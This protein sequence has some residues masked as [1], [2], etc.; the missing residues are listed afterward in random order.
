MKLIDG[1][2]IANRI[3]DAIAIETYNIYKNGGSRPGLGIII[4]GDRVDSKLYVKIKQAEAVKLGIDTSLYELPADISESELLNVIRFLNEDSGID[5]IL[6]QLPLPEG[7]NTDLIIGAINSKKDADGF[8]PQHPDYVVSPVLGAVKEMITE[9]GLDLK[10][11][12]AAILY[13]SEIFGTEAKNLLTSLG[14]AQVGGLSLKDFSSLSEIK[15]QLKLEE[16]KK[17]TVEADILV[18]AVGLPKFITADMVKEQAVIIDIGTNRVNDKVVGDVD[19]DGV[20]DKVSF[21]SPVPGGVGPLTVAL[22][23]KNVLEIYNRE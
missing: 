14:L 21:I 7:L 6:V 11:K 12:K 8:H 10:S 23:F 5:A 2:L 13:N 3:K 22:L 4:V 1:R 18:V 20:K 17:I 15:R 9:T 19:F 16:V